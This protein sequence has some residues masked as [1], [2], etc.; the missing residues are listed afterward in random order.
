M[1]GQSADTLVIFSYNAAFPSFSDQLAGVQDGLDGRPFDILFLDTK[2]LGTEDRFPIVRDELAA[3]IDAN[4]GYRLVLTADD[5]ALRFALEQRPLLHPETPIVF[6]AVNDLER[7]RVLEGDPLVTGIAERPSIEETLLLMK[8]LFPSREIAV[9]SDATPS[10]RGDLALFTAAVETDDRLSG[11]RELSLDTLSHTDLHMELTEKNG[12][13]AYLILSPYLDRNG[14]YVD[15]DSSLQLLLDAAPDSVFFHLWK[16]GMG[17]GIFGGKLVSHYQQ[18]RLAAERAAGILDGTESAD[19]PA[20]FT[21]QNVYVFDYPVI[22]SFGISLSRLPQGAEL[23]NPPV[24]RTSEFRVRLAGMATVFFPAIAVLL[25]IAFL[26]LRLRR[27]K[28][29]LDVVSDRLK[30]VFRFFPLSLT[31]QNSETHVVEYAV[32]QTDKTLGYPRTD[33]IGHTDTELFGLSPAQEAR[34]EEALIRKTGTPVE[35]SARLFPVN[36]DPRHTIHSVRLAQKD[37]SGST[38]FLCIQQD[39]SDELRLLEEIQSQNARNAALFARNTVPILVCRSSDAMIIDANPQATDFYGRSREELIGSPW[40]SLELSAAS[41]I[42]GVELETHTHHSNTPRLV[43]V[44]RTPVESGTET[45]EY[46]MIQDVTV[47][48]EARNEIEDAN[49]AKMFFMANVSHEL[50]TPLNGILG[51]AEEIG[52]SSLSPHQQECLANLENAA[53][54]L[55]TVLYGLL[56]YAKLAKDTLTPLSQEFEAGELLEHARRYFEHSARVKGLDFVLEMSPTPCWIRSDKVKLGQILINL[57]GNAVR[58]TKEGHVWTSVTCGPELRIV[59]S[60]TGPGIPPEQ[61]TRV[62]EPF[63]KLENPFSNSSRGLGL[64]LT[65][66]RRLTELLGGTFDIES[67]TR[68]GT[69]TTVRIPIQRIATRT[70]ESRDTVPEGYPDSKQKTILVVE[71]DGVNRLFFRSV[72]AS[73]GYSV[74]EAQSGTQALTA[75]RENSFDAIITDIG[76]PD[77]NGIEVIREL[78][79]YESELHRPAVPVLALTAYATERTREECLAAGMDSFLSKPVTRKS[80]LSQVELLFQGK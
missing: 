33:L 20:L 52:Q 60:D 11:I 6:F 36:E 32:G 12:T 40:T 79:R 68:D 25:L 28:R 73:R 46:R 76:L 78:R 51:M 53:A 57:V 45:I 64:G 77:I 35:N 14:T 58:F 27:H 42:D 9:I 49:K 66:V 71:D 65:I 34:D 23:L 69:V 43:R 61:I 41:T 16:H 39:I 62:M 72:L 50:R 48:I 70:A 67:D 19:Q 10:G 22:E 44:Y 38:K 18:G 59:V 75:I 7:I 31:V 80:L 13:A 63:Q 17:A 26:Y 24:F 30:T 21:G 1:Y 37:R 74:S 2:R 4:G 55:N 15:F 5:N 54:E 8:E 29:E 47:E 56:D 3:L